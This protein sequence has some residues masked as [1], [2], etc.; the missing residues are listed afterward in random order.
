MEIDPTSKEYRAGRSAARKSIKAG[1]PRWTCVARNDPYKFIDDQTGLPFIDF[2]QKSDEIEA[3]AAG[4][5]DEILRAIGKGLITLDFRPLLLSRDDLKNAF[6][7][8]FVGLL[9]LG[10]PEIEYRDVFSAKLRSERVRKMYGIPHDPAKRNVFIELRNGQGKVFR[11]FALYDDPVELALALDNRVLVS[12][13]ASA[14][15][16][17]DLD[18]SQILNL[19][20]R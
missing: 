1:F 18:T 9:S 6:G 8:A 11:D 14:Y 13:T 4:A 19:Y 10:N 5:N 12:R 20:P 3:L 7:Q 17:R 15:S 16:S 2:V